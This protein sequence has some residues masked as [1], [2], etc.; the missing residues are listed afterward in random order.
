LKFPCII[1]WNVV[2]GETEIIRQ[3]QEAFDEANISVPQHL[4]FPTG[5]NLSEKAY[6]YF[7]APKNSRFRGRPNTL[8]PLVVTAH[9]GPTSQASTV[10]DLRKQYLTSRGFAVLDVNYRGSTGYGRL[11]R[12]ALMKGLG[13]VD[14]EDACN[15][16]LFLAKEHKVDKAKLCIT[17][18]SAGGYV[19]LAALAFKNVFKAGAS[20]FGI[21]DLEM[22]EKET[23]KFESRYNHF[24]VGPYPEA[25]DEYRR[26]SPLNNMEGLNCPVVFFQGD[27][28]KIVP[29]NQAESMYDALKEKGITT[30]LAIFEGEGHGFRI[31]ENIELS[32]DGEYYFF[33][34]VLGIPCQEPKNFEKMNVVNL[35][36]I[37]KI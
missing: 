33:C 13:I 30:A 18:R 4:S 17:G 7:Y 34:R 28:D 5:D 11:F 16:A 26:R 21:G 29:K 2:T 37:A 15:G 1:R 31:A 23:H 3:T 14:V 20:H 36:G 8:P 10:L 25:V 27:S 9:G 22:L 12:Q 24:L 19:T 35:P 6:G 32:I